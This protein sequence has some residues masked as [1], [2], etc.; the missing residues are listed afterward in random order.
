MS[1]GGV[2]MY[3]KM[4]GKEFHFHRVRIDLLETD[5]REPFRF[6]DK[7]TIRDLLRHN[8]YQHL[9]EKVMNEYE[10]ILDVPAG[11]ALYNLKKKND[12]FYKEFLNNYGDLAYCQFVV[13]GNETLLNKKGVYTIIMNDKI[14]FAGICNNKF[15]LRFN[16]HIG[17]V[18]PKSCFRD[19]TATHCHINSKIAWHILDSNIYFQVCPLND[20]EEMKSVKNWLIDR[21]EPLWN[22]RFGSDVIYTYN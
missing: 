14:V 20:L 2:F 8:R 12:P 15:K 3:V 11:P 9:R 18:S 7:K 5:I 13:K 21:F 4:N 6:F 19:G 17:N 16:Q 22:L 1:G 10:E